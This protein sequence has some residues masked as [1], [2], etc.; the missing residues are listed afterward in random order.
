MKLFKHRRTRL[1]YTLIE[2]SVVLVLVVLISSTL[3]SMLN[4]Q[5]SFYSWWN[6]QKF[7]AE[8]APLTN[9]MVVRVFSK[10]DDIE[11]FADRTSA[12]TGGNGVV[13]DGEV[14]LLGFLQGDGSKKY[15]MIE[16]DGDEDEL[17]YNVLNDA[18]N[19]VIS[20]W[21]IATGI[22]DASFDVVNSVHQ[23]TLTGPYGGQVTYATTPTL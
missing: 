7:I 4:Q 5:V 6:T 12:L 20:S 15:G 17:V 9:S 13:I 3:V 14:I 2:L 8:D 18:G 22:A 10:A 23:L 21:T 19:G 1:G 11:I 16:Y